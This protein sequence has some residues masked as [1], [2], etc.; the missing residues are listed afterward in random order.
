MHPTWRST[1]T[2][3]V[4]GVI[5][6]AM[7]GV[8]QPAGYLKDYPAWIGNIGWFGMLACLL[9]LLVSG[10]WAGALRMRRP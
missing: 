7:S 6:L 1:I 2:L 4:A 5:L 10:L 8:G 3:F 9:L